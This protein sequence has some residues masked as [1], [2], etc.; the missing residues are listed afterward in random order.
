MIFNAG[1]LACSAE[2]QCKALGNKPFDKKK[3]ELKKAKVPLDSRR[4]K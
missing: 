3:T 2:A 4:P 1:A